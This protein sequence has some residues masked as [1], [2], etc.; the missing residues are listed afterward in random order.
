[1]V[2][3]AF[4]RLVSSQN[5]VWYRYVVVILVAP[6]LPWEKL[7][8]CTV[9]SSPSMGDILILWWT[10][11]LL[12][13]K[14]SELALMA[15]LMLVCSSLT[16][17]VVTH[18]PTSKLMHKYMSLSY[19]LIF[20]KKKKLIPISWSPSWVVAELLVLYCAPGSLHHTPALH[21]TMYCSHR[22]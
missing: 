17:S 12:L 2:Q 8:G 18:T 1:M 16:F 10:S 7:P 20:N 21:C 14:L 9:L 13:L 22:E 15:K 3:A 5:E 19:P 4:L 11:G 6:L